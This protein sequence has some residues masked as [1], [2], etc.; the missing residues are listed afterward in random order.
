LKFIFGSALIWL[1]PQLVEFVESFFR[2]PK[3]FVDDAKVTKKLMI[4]DGCLGCGLDA[5]GVIHKV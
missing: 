2:P 1:T 5:R 4:L 3:G